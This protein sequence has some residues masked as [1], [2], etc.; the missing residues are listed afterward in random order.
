MNGSLRRFAGVAAG[1]AGAVAVASVVTSCAVAG[2]PAAAQTTE[3]AP[4]APAT[5]LPMEAPPPPP[6][7]PR[8]VQPPA[9]ASNTGADD[10]AIRQVVVA[11]TGAYNAEDWDGFMAQICSARAGN[12]N[13]DM[14]KNQRAERGPMQ[15]TV[16]AV[17]VTGDTATATTVMTQRVTVNAPYHM[18]RENG[19]KI[20]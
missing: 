7:A 5:L 14:I 15:V 11:S 2:T 16:T 17:T 10:A 13:L 1:V 9:P 6:P 3:P 8:P 12:F 4:P 19:W 18:V 20:C